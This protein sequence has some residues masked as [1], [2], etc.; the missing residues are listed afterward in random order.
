[1][2]RKDVMYARHPPLT[3]GETASLLRA[4]VAVCKWVSARVDRIVVLSRGFNRKTLLHWPR[5]LT[6][7][8]SWTRRDRGIWGGRPGVFNRNI[9]RSPLV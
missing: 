7:W 9:F 6:I 4:V 8:R 2:G 3:V 1:M 5:R